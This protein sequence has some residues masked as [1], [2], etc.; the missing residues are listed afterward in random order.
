MDLVG[1]KE[2]VGLGL[3]TV[4]SRDFFHLQGIGGAEDISGEIL[5][6]K[7]GIRKSD[8]SEKDSLK[9]S[10]VGKWKDTFVM[11]TLSENGALYWMYINSSSPGNF[12]LVPIKERFQTISYC[13]IGLKLI[14]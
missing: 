5:K 13:K 12:S 7:I 11:L 9:G 2:Y 8:S 4:G 14:G 10:T 3:V 6:M 1:W